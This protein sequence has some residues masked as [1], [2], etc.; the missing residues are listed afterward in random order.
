MDSGGFGNHF[1]I[2]GFMWAVFGLAAVTVVAML[3]AGGWLV[4]ILM[5]RLACA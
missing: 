5:V 1:P 3:A 2:G 4:W